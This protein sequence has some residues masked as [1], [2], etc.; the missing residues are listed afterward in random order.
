[1]AQSPERIK[2]KDQEDG[3]ENESGRNLILVRGLEEY[4]QYLE[5]LNARSVRL[6]EKISDIGISYIDPFYNVRGQD[7]YEAVFEKLFHYAPGARIRI[8]DSAW[9]VKR[10]GVVYLQWC[11]SFERKGRMR[12]ITGMAEVEFKPD[13]KVISH[14][15]HWDSA[16]QFLVNFPVLGWLLDKA[17]AKVS[18]PRK[19]SLYRFG[20]Y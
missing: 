6:I 13:G 7:A 10:E 8:I 5:R 3:L 17:R 19:Y 2:D 18:R 12:E 4:I 9:S 14:T 1:M 20:K 16:F 11:L 15:N